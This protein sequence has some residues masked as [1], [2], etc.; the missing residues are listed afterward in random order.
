M[1]KIG[2]RWQWVLRDAALIWILL[3]VSVVLIGIGGTP[4]PT[5]ELGLV[6]LGI[7][8]IGFCI[9]GIVVKNDRFRHLLAVAAVLWLLSAANM[10]GGTVSVGMWMAG[11]MPLLLAVAIGGVISLAFV[12]DPFV[13]GSQRAVVESD[14]EDS[15]IKIGDIS[16]VVRKE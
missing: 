13:N 7:E 9:S 4:T 16:S 1:E 10:I 14:D 12:Q 11:I 5:I 2:L 6:A 3:T 8:S 15:R